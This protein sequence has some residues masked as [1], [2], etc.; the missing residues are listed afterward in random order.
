M[1]HYLNTKRLPQSKHQAFSE[2]SAVRDLLRL[3]WTPQASGSEPVADPVF[4]TKVWR[5]LASFC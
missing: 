4:S 5:F 1:D 3:T 2:S